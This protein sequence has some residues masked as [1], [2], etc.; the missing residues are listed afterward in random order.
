MGDCVARETG[1]EHPFAVLKMLKQL[2]VLLRPLY[3]YLYIYIYLIYLSKYIYIYM[4][5]S[6]YLSIIINKSL[7]RKAHFGLAE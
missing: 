3:L 4:S 5:V 6:I 1:T 7:K 2:S